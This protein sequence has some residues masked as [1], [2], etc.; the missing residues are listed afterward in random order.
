MQNIEPERPWPCA[1]VPSM[2]TLDDLAST[3][4]AFGIR[5]TPGSLQNK[6]QRL[7]VKTG[8]VFNSRITGYGRVGYHDPLAC[9]ALATAH[10]SEL[11]AT[12]LRTLYSEARRRASGAVRRDF[13]GKSDSAPIR[14]VMAGGIH[15]VSPVHVRSALWASPPASNRVHRSGPRLTHPRLAGMPPLDAVHLHLL[16]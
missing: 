3:A 13:G 8:H 14:V 11:P 16:P 6:L 12:R 7:G 5:C 9:W 2:Q 10:Y 15:R 1:W 4:E